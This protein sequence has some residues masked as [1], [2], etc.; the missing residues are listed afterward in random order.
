MASSLS[1]WGFENA[2]DRSH[3]ALPFGGFF[4]KLLAAGF[5]QLIEARLAVV[6]G[7]APLGGNPAARFQTLKC[8]VKRAVLD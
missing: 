3:Q 1:G 6:A 8:R 4:H 5:G 7:R 2:S